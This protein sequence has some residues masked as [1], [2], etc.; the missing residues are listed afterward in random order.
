[1]QSCDELVG[2]PGV[3]LPGGDKDFSL[4]LFRFSYLGIF[5]PPVDY[6]SVTIYIDP[7]SLEHWFINFRCLLKQLV[8]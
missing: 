3:K 7:S 4:L 2:T 5:F 8:D 6:F 1:M